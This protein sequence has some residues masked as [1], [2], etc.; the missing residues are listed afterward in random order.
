[1]YTEAGIPIEAMREDDKLRGLLRS[2]RRLL[3]KRGYRFST[4]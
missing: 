1:M 2:V 3:V 4:W